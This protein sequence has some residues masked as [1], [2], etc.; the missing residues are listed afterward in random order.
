MTDPL[1]NRIIFFHPGA[2]SS[3]RK[4]RLLFASVLLLAILALIWPI[5]PMF[6]GTTPQILGLPL[7]FAW[8]VLWLLITFVGLVWLYRRDEAESPEGPSSSA[9]HSEDN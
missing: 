7:S 1:P 6:S 8:V 5:Y 4:R 9:V 3:Y 2:S